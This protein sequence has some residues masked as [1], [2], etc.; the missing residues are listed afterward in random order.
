MVNL[1]TS[2]GR[3]LDQNLLLDRLEAG[4]YDTR[5]MMEFRRDALEVLGL[6][7]SR[8]RKVFF[9]MCWDTTAAVVQHGRKVPLIDVWVNMSYWAVLLQKGTPQ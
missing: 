2:S 7:R 8:K 9:R 1:S 6:S 5:P 3:V 4:W